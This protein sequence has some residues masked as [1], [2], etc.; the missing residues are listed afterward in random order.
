M[1][2]KLRLGPSKAKARKG[3]VLLLTDGQAPA[4]GL[5]ELAVTM[6]AEGT[7]ISTIAL[8]GDAD[9]TLLKVAAAGSDI[10]SRLGMMRTR[11]RSVDCASGAPAKSGWR[12]SRFGSARTRSR[13]RAVPALRKGEEVESGVSDG[14]G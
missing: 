4:A 8:G 1:K 14:H 11:N 9:Q 5:R 3:H 6:A 12:G 10:L 13:A 2:T 7:T